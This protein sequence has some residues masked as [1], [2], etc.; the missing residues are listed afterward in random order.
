MVA[1]LV[2][3][4]TYLNREIKYVASVIGGLGFG[5]FLDELGKFITRDNNYFFEPA[6]AFIYV[7]FVLL[8]LGLRGLEKHFKPTRKEYTANALEA[9]REVILHDL[10][11]EEKKLTLHFLAKSDSQDP[12]VSSLKKLILEIEPIP[13]EGVGVLTKV[14]RFFAK[15]YHFLTHKPWFAKR[16]VVFFVLFSIV[17]FFA[18]VANI[19]FSINFFEWGWIIST[20]I[21]AIFVF[22][23]VYRISENK[24]RSYEMFRTAVLISIFL[25][26]FFQFY[27]V[28]LIALVALFLNALILGSLEYLIYQESFHQEKDG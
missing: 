14:K 17:N 11:E 24:R 6:I 10:D 2:L 27:K 9:V 18:A 3:L 5:L 20:I 15:N 4:L 8:F 23:G 26:Q 16:L 19:S 13:T 12:I 22:L 21:S 28:Q 1:A 7:I 25:T